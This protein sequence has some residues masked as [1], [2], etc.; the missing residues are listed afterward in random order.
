MSKLE[1]VVNK[2]NE[3]EKALE[4]CI[5][6]EFE[7]WDELIGGIDAG[8][9][10]CRVIHKHLSRRLRKE[11]PL[12]ILELPLTEE[13]YRGEFG[14]K[15]NPRLRKLESVAKRFLEWVEDVKIEVQFLLAEERNRRASK[16]GAHTI[17]LG[18]IRIMIPSDP[19]SA[20]YQGFRWGYVSGLVTGVPAL[21]GLLLVVIQIQKSFGL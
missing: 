13:A 1:E 16:G 12:P 18:K 15:T 5:D 10:K 17:T 2:L 11:Y 3:C 19:Q 21:A 9:R 14:R 8:V 20:F 6:L 4:Y 7:E